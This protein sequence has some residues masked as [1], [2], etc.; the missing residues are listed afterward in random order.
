MKLLNGLSGCMRFS[1]LGR[2]DRR[3]NR[4]VVFLNTLKLG[5]NQNKEAGS[6]LF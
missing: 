3:K 1:R 2:I 5:E 4:G 6:N